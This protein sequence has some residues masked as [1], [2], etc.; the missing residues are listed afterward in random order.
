MS[1]VKIPFNLCF[2]LSYHILYLYV[3]L[4]EKIALH[5]IKNI[6]CLFLN[7]K[8][9]ILI[10]NRFKEIYWYSAKQKSAVSEGITYD[11]TYM[12]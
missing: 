12:I 4:Q 5:G 11:T 7:A 8:Q 10:F 9:M 2:P 6:I 1:I 3:S